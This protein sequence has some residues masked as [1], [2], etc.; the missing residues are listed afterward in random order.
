MKT[1]KSSRKDIHL[2]LLDLYSYLKIDKIRIVNKQ[3]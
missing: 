2:A 1:N 3:I